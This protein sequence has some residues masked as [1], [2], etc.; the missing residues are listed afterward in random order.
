MNKEINYT[1]VALM[2]QIKFIG[3][4]DGILSSYVDRYPNA[5]TT[6]IPLPDD[7]P[8]DIIPRVEI[9]HADLNITVSFAKSRADIF[10]NSSFVDRDVL[11]HFL[12]MV[13]NLGITIGRL[14][15]V[16]RTVYRELDMQ[17]V[18]RKLKVLE[19]T[20]EDSEILEALQRVNKKISLENGGNPVECN[21]IASLVFGRENEKVALL[22][23]RDVN[24]LMT[25]N[26]SLKNYNDI[27]SILDLLAKEA[28]NDFF[29]MAE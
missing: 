3:S 29:D 28:K 24:T 27:N 10:F 4:F 21:N 15:F 2:Y 20:V 6:K 25:K 5:I 12:E 11:K 18:K 13:V 1:Q 22:L 16:Q 26:L 17:Y 14:G 19:T 7:F 23:E 9:R 8:E